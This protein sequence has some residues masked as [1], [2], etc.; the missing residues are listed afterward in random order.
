MRRVFADAGYWIALLNPKDGL[1]AKAIE[2]SAT[3]GRSRILTSEMVLTEVLNAFAAKGESLRNA[4]CAMVGK[5]RANSSADR[6]FSA[7]GVQCAARG[8]TSGTHSRDRLVNHAAAA[9]PRP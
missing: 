4:A 6:D 9:H 7:G 1:H 2:V 8:V 3:L 5:I